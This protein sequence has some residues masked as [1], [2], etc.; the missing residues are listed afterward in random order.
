M[1]KGF[2]L[3]DSEILK[4]RTIAINPAFVWANANL[5]PVHLKRNESDLVGFFSMK[6]NGFKMFLHSWPFTEWQINGLVAFLAL[7]LCKSIWIECFGVWIM[8]WIPKK[9]QQCQNISFKNLVSN[10]Q[11][12]E[13]FLKSQFYTYMCNARTDIWIG[14][15]GYSVTGSFWPSINGN[16]YVLV[17]TLLISGATT[18]NRIVSWIILSKY[19]ISCKAS[20]VN[21]LL[22]LAKTSVISS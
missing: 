21:S 1:T 7:F 19:S 16:V 5:I 3:G 11:I 13:W 20:N 17:Q 12:V 15:P 10:C 4:S 22:C 14:V 18:F 6:Q 9:W 8:L 2:C